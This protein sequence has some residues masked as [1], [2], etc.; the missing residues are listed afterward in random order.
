MLL[1]FWYQFGEETHMGVMVRGADT[2]GHMLK[3]TPVEGDRHAVRHE[4]KM[5]VLLR[6]NSAAQCMLTHFP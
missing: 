1:T 3:E 6:R 4:I 5:N 2:F